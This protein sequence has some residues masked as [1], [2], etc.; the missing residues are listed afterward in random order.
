MISANINAV[1]DQVSVL[2]QPAAIA[3]NTAN[4]KIYIL[5][6]GAGSVSPVS[7]IDNFVA[8]KIT[9][10][11]RPIWGVMSP[12]GVHV[13][14]VNQGDGTVNVIDTL[15]DQ[16]IGDPSLPGKRSRSRH[17]RQPAAN[18]CGV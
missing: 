12:D 17:Y 14:I 6:S 5:N 3:G 1:T 11:V 4:S 9:V 8:P 2:S 7:T 10:G 18:V 16:V 15:L 13:F